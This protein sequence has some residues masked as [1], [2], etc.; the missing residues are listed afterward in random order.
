MHLAPSQ[1][2]LSN[3]AAALPHVSG[4]PGP[5]VLRRLRQP[6]GRSADDVLNPSRARWPRTRTG[7]PKG[8]PMFTCCSLVEGGTRLSACGLTSTYSVVI[9]CWPHHG[10]VTPPRS[11]P[12][13]DNRPQ[14]A[15]RARPRSIGFET[16]VRQDRYSHRFLAYT[17][18]TTL[19]APTPSDSADASR[20]CQGCSHPSR[21]SPQ[22][23]LP[24]ASNPCHGRESG[25][26]LSPPLEQQAPHGAR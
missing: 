20:L 17:S 21:A 26:G 7:R 5:G 15:H 18:S 9:R 24:P 13:T 1:H 22:V 8:L 23:R 3:L 16:V 12:P 2:L 4:S 10:I 19:A 6:S 25:E 11:S 14:M